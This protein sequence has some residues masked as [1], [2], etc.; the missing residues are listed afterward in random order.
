CMSFVHLHLHTEYS[1]LDGLT[2]IKKLANTLKEFEMPGCA[3]TDHGNMYGAVEFYK[4]FQK[5]ELKPVIGCEI[6]TTTGSRFDK[7]PNNKKLNHLFL[8]KIKAIT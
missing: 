5:N 4:T 1:L 3:I 8:F 7:S 6:Y 2:K